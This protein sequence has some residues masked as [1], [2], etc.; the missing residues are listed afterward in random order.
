MTI[1]QAIILGVLQGLTEFLPISSSGHLVVLPF[2]LNW[3]L[4]E[5][6]MFIFNVLV[7]VG[8]LVAVI[9]YFWKD[10]IGII[11]DFFKQLINGTP[12]ATINSR[13]GWLL[14]VATIPAGLAGLFLHDLVEATFT[15]PLFAGIALM[16]TALLMILGE[17]IS[18]RVG[19]I[20]DITL[21]EALFMG[22]MQSLAL[23]PGISRSGATISGGMMRHLR[24]E[25]AGKF[26]FLMA[27]PIMLAAGGLSTYQMLT[28]VPD[29][30]SFLPMMAIGFITA[31]VVGYIA[32]RWL[33]RF[34]VNNSLIYFSIYCLL[35]GGATILVSV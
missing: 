15:S 12:F 25:A 17:K 11:T 34:L 5:K 10:L 9:I 19:I 16:V 31:L 21:L 30:A 14:I 26:S 23:F 1:L 13:L 8:T 35:L 22:V 24:R 32:I 7:Q 20:Q 2:F 18:Q 3:Q 28:E 4:P 27:V 6:E 29:L 33:L